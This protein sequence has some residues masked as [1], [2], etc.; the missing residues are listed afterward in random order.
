ME[1]MGSMA[2]LRTFWASMASITYG[3]PEPENAPISCFALAESMDENEYSS[4]KK[5]SSN[6][7]MSPYVSIQLYPPPPSSGGLLRFLAMPA[8]FPLKD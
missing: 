5:H 4:T 2:L 3:L 8:H 7:T 1:S 6:V